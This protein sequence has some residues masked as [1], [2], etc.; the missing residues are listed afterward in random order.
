MIFVMRANIIVYRDTH[1]KQTS[2]LMLQMNMQNG[3]TYMEQ[4]NAQTIYCA[5]RSRV[6]AVLRPASTREVVK[7]KQ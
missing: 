6:E 5:K 2:A 1:Q 3:Q 7:Q 4:G